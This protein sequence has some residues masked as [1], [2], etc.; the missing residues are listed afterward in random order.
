[1]L[2]ILYKYT[3]N[4]FTVQCPPTTS[5]ILPTGFILR[6]FPTTYISTNT[7]IKIEQ[8]IISYL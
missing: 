3:Y 8:Y 2:H 5:L 6:L 4:T 1:M 7:T